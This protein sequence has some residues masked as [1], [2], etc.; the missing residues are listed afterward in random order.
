MAAAASTPAGTEITNQATAIF[1][2]V[3]PGGVGQATSNTVITTVQAVCAVSVAADGGVSPTILPGEQSILRFTVV[4]TGNQAF[5]LPVSASSTGNNPAPALTIYSDLNGNGQLDAGEPQVSQ[6]NLAA[7][8]AAK[9]LVV[10][11]TNASS[12]GNAL[13]SLIASCGAAG[14]G[15]ASATGQVRL[16]APPILTTRKTFTPTLIKPGSETTVKVSTINDGAGDSREVV[17]TD[18]LTNQ[19][20]QG[21]SFVPGS[22]QT[23]M[24]TLEYTSDGTTW[25]T[26]AATP[27]HG[28]RV[29]VASLAPNEQINLS[30]RMLADASAENKVIP[31]TAMAQTSGNITSSTAQVDVRYQPGMS[32]GPVGKPLAP[33]G[34][35]EDTQSKPF[36][37]VGQQVC[38][39]HTLQN[40]GDVKDTFQ[41]VVTYPQGAANT[42]MYGA[43]GQPL[44]LPLPLNPGE[45]ALVRICYTPTQTG[46]LETLITA[47][48]TRGTSNTTKDIIK[49]IQQGLPELSKSYTA[50]TVDANGQTRTLAPGAN[51][52]VGDTITYTLTVRNPYNRPLTNV[53]VSDPIPAHVNF[54]SADQGGVVSGTPGQETV[55]WNLGTL[56]AGETRTY[57]IVTKVSDR[58]VDGENLKNIFNMVSSELPEPLPSNEVKTPVWN[59]KLIIDKQVS[60]KVVTYGDRVTYTLKITNASATTAIEN[61]VVS[62]TPAAGLEYIPSTSLLGGQPLADPTIVGGVL[63]WNVGTIPAGGSITIL[64]DMRITPQAASELVNIVEVSGVGAGG[65]ARAIASNQARA[66]TK[67]DPLKFA[68]IADIIGTVFVDRNRNG[69][70]DA[71]LD[72]PV[73]RARVI[74]A[75]GR[76]ALTDTAGRYHFAN[77]PYGTWA[78][79]LDPNTTPYPPLKLPQEG[80]LSGTQTVQ[81]AGLTSVNFP[82][83]P[84]GG[85]I[86]A[87]RQTTLSMGNVT[88]EKAV[89]AVPGGYVV[90]L[91]I[92]TPEALADFNL[93]D[94]L[95]GGAILKEG[96]NTLTSNLPV[97]ET[98]LTYHFDWTGDPQGATTD[99]VVSWRY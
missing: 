76:L 33:E 12:L 52:T 86:A 23:N 2:P 59:A 51:V 21:L 8:A 92:K 79:R 40:T 81:V 47:T 64:Y 89:Y 90:T 53:V 5:N 60:A 97:G 10:V 77:V 98:N 48:G 95:P 62:D 44:V 39:D 85:D 91:K 96:R 15:T 74:L 37:V 55:T 30:F 61:A 94:P 38:F 83:A 41:I 67:L 66:T 72:T 93:N 4:N 18:M 19:L 57:T 9:L 50:T 43:N 34:T 49:D 3:N 56:G 20:A 58:S 65:A 31:N 6:L 84:L 14:S 69:L 46:P 87:L 24:G 99:P 54:V 17:L 73:D 16:T 1:D 26:T 35:P 70:Y 88:V 22:A 11:Q 42:V 29:R 27:V 71:G 25:S 7:D 32:I 36:A 80:G 45:T 75:G 82:L 78:L 13:V 28:I 63:H 68:P